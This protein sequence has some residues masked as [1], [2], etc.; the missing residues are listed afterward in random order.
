M[1]KEYDPAK[2]DNKRIAVIG[3]GATGCLTA[4]ELAKLG[5]TVT[6]IDAGAPGNGSSSRSAACFRQQFDTP[7]TVRGMRYASDY[8]EKWGETVGGAHSPMR[9]SGYL[10][11]H[12]LR[13]DRAAVEVKIAM[14]REA[15]LSDVEI[16]DKATIEDK[17]P[18]VAEPL[19]QFAT[20]CPSDGF[21]SPD[22]VYTDAVEAL[23]RDHQVTTYFFNGV[24]KCE[25]WQG[26]L[27]TLILE[28]GQCITVDL[29][30]NATNA[31]TN[32]V[33]QMLDAAQIPVL[34][35]R[36][37]LVHMNV[38]G[39]EHLLDMPMVIGP[40]GCYTRPTS[41][42][43]LMGGWLHHTNGE[44]FPTFDF[45]DEAEE[46]IRSEYML[47]FR[48]EA[49]KYIPELNE[50]PGEMKFTMGLYADTPDHN[51]VIGYDSRRTSQ[52]LIHAVGFSGHGLMH[53]PFTARIVAELVQAGRDLD[54]ITIPGFGTV[55]VRPYHIGRE[56]TGGEGM[57][58]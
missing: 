7:S 43:H 46:R 52:N 55:D 27:T 18:E 36:R 53:A 22:I 40:N 41:D 39:H 6:L 35:R 28:K 19:I 15:G 38:T 34:A 37:Y 17:F 9:R 24:V 5:H 51:P 11:L 25:H 4:L 14:Q 13:T 23:R 30:V 20:W 1:T 33:N 16:L 49:T 58:I 3:A 31:W 10:F 47:W 2:P 50:L 32:S 21:L 54:E 48:E 44:Q 57:V 8:Y 12:D 56:Y 26:G 29:V 42:G 45:Q